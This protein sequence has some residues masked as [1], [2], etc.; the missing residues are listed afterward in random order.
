MARKTF[1]KEEIKQIVADENVEFIRV[2]FTDVLGA[3]KNVE[4]PTSQLDKVLDN[5]LMFDGSSIEGFVRINESDMYLY[6]DLSTFMIFPWATDG[7]GGKVARLIAD[8]YTT[9]REPFAGDPRH[10]LRTVLTEAR[11]AGFTSFNVGTEPEFFLFKLDEK[12]NPTTELNDKGGYF[13]LAPLDMG[14]NVRREI[15]LTLEKMGFEI[16]A[17]HHEVA[18]G[19]HEVDFKYASA[20]EA[21][22]NI[23]TFKLVVKTIARKNGYFATFMPKPVAG[24]NG[25]GMHTNMSLFTKEGNAFEDVSDEMGLSKAAYNFLGGVLEHATAFTALANPTVN[26]YKRLTPGFEAPVYVAW[27]ASNRSPMVRV[28]A[29]RGQSTRLELRSVDPTANPY[30]SLAAILASGLDGI[31]RELEP[32]ASV[33]KNIYLMDEIERERAGITDLPDTLLAAVRELAADDVVRAA[34]GEHIADKF[35]EAKKIEYTSY[36]QYVSQWETDS[37]L[38]KY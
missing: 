14:E 25:S 1:T 30:T 4:V 23:Q 37:Y 5:D 34:I 19:Q 26:S 9:D 16:E 8:I 21:A 7:H 31:K 24:I 22:D 38:E 12:G 11:E 2:T 33:D 3:I 6:P 13:D 27:S 32:L 15:V 35:I 18:E 10:A 28:P 20:L 29:S 36:R 17:A